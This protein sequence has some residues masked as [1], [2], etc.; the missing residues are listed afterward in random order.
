MAPF[1]KVNE[2]VDG[3]REVWGFAT[4]ERVDKA[5][6][7]ADFDSTVKAFEKWSGEASER[8]EG[9]SLG[10]V[11]LMHQKIAAGKSIHWEPSEK[12]IKKADGTDEVIKGIYVGA[13]IPPTKS[14]I[15]KDVDEGILTGF[16][17]GGGYAKRWYDS[18]DKAFR[19]TPTISE[20]SLVDNPCVEGADIMNVIAKAD[21]PW[22]N[23]NFNDIE[24]G[25]NILENENQELNKRATIAGS[26]EELRTLI[27][28]AC[29]NKF[30]GMN[31]YW[32]G[33]VCAT[34]ID[35][36]VVYDYNKSKYYEVSYSNGDGVITIG[37]DLTEVLE[38]TSYV[39]VDV[40]K[41]IE[42]ELKK[43]AEALAETSEK[44]AEKTAD[45][46]LK[47]AA[48]AIGITL[49]QFKELVKVAV[50]QDDE[51]IANVKVTHVDGGGDY[52]NNKEFP[53]PPGG[54]EAVNIVGAQA[55]VDE[56]HE[57]TYKAALDELKKSVDGLMGESNNLEK[58][59][60]AISKDRMAHL[61]HAKGHIDAAMNG[62]SYGP[63]E[64][65]EVGSKS[66][67]G[68]TGEESPVV[69][70][71][72]DDLQKS[73]NG[74][75]ESL[76]KALASELEKSFGKIEALFKSIPNSQMFEDLQKNLKSL[77]RLDSLEK[78]VKEI[79]ETPQPNNLVLNGG[80]PDMFKVLGQN[81]HF[82]LA[83]SE[84]AI[85][86]KFVSEIQDPLSRDKVG[87]ELAIRK[88][89]S[90]FNK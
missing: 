25:D 86:E 46:K 22:N 62:T 85:L 17:I 76:N 80:S 8:T 9:K 18:V 23:R 72:L 34:W 57:A 70:A 32:D 77:G 42:G 73:F 79:H 65:A 35:K 74:T 47:K 55:K 51:N 2:T 67:Q 82:D 54:T 58:L 71:I 49:E 14:E 61:K 84:D 90:A 60:V 5:G 88:A 63:E 10:N 28:N 6:E 87:Q 16:S 33:Y 64:H 68:S 24:K 29:T 39:P 19:Y 37:D 11:R 40:Q 21:G 50:T 78:L 56:A 30:K 66:G 31:N 81:G 12:T 13:Y 83:K 44:E 89:R 15:I 3:G 7:I 45:N 4:L 27:S 20:Y 69:K 43:R 1:A 36:V 41:L 26:F 75:N 59:N 38:V 52:D 53:N 48:E